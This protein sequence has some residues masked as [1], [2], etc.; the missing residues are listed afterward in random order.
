MN[1]EH[2]SSVEPR[3]VQPPEAEK[4][5]PPK[6]PTN[7]NVFRI[8]NVTLEITPEEE[9]PPGIPACGYKDQMEMLV[10]L[11]E[12]QVSQRDL[13]DVIRFVE[14]DETKIWATNDQ[15]AIAVTDAI[16]SHAKN[17]KHTD[18]SVDI[19]QFPQ[20]RRDCEN[21]VLLKRSEK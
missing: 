19:G 14:T 15:A 6:Q 3:P 9:A 17:L 11:E 16:V 2:T 5:V 7:K 12:G 21:K 4:E 18:Y 8:G 20:C 1:Y 13:P 10:C